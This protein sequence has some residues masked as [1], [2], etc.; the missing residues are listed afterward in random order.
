MRSSTSWS[1]YSATSCKCCK[2]GAKQ[3]FDGVYVYTHTQLI[4][5]WLALGQIQQRRAV[6]L[7]ALTRSC[8]S[9]WLA[10]GFVDG[11]LGLDVASGG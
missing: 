4:P 10:L 11:L 5:I 6:L 1:L 8:T 2:P 3:N 7:L 9:P